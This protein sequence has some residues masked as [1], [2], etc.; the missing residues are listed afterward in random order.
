MVLGLLAGF[1]LPAVAEEISIPSSYAECEAGKMY[2]RKTKLLCTYLVPE[3][4]LNGTLTKDYLT[5]QRSKPNYQYLQSYDCKYIDA[6]NLDAPRFVSCARDR[7]PTQYP[8][9]DDDCRLFYYNPGYAFPESLKECL[10]REDRIEDVTYEL[11]QI[12]RIAVS[13]APKT[14][15]EHY[16]K[17]EANGIVEKCQLAGGEAHVEDGHP[18]CVLT[19]TEE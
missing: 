11:K 13:Y 19:F 2:T 7:M 10:A 18:V 8:G 15:S 6:E 5:C 12:C 3:S 14:K 4:K 1:T 16:D 9:F 17:G